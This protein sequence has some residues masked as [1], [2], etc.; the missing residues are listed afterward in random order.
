MSAAGG[1]DDGRPRPVQERVVVIDNRPAGAYRQLVLRAPGSAAR[2][3]PGQFAAIAVGDEPTATLLRRAFSLHH[4][5][6][7]SADGPTLEIVVAAHGPGSSWITRR[8]PGD[9]LDVVAPLG[10][11]FPL[12]A[13]SAAAVLVG[14]GYG[15][16]PMAWWARLL[17]AHG[18]AVTAV[19]GAGDADRLFGVQGLQ[20]LA[21]RVLVTTDDGSAGTRGRVTDVL[22]DLLGDLLTDQ[23]GG[24]GDQAT[25]IYACG[26]MEMLRAVTQVAALHGARAWCTVEESM[27]CGVGIC[28]TCVLPVRGDDGLTRMTR[29]CV[30]GPT[31]DGA[32]VRWDAV[33]TGPGGG[34]AVPADCVGA[35]RR[36]EGTVDVLPV[37]NDRDSNCYAT[38]G[39]RAG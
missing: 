12:P 4:A 36:P 18:S 32:A 34:S 14:G 37:V 13:P 38:W 25:E 26:P 7:D 5:T 31:F 39:G 17:R 24:P 1:L 20:A 3:L 11:P 23:Q 21:D 35:P 8:R 33:R 9:E 30:E 2:A 16:A 28:M 22:P 29:T 27:A 19:I 6:A 15:S 10:R